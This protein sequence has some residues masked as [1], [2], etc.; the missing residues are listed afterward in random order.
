MKWN[1]EKVE[2]KTH[3]IQWKN[4]VLFGYTQFRSLAALSFSQI[5]RKFF[6][7][8]TLFTQNALKNI[9]KYF[10]LYCCLY[11]K[12]AW[13]I[14]WQSPTDFD[15]QQKEK[16]FYATNSTQIFEISTNWLLFFSLDFKWFLLLNLLYPYLAF[17]IQ[18]N[19]SIKLFLWLCLLLPF[20]YPLIYLQ[21]NLCWRQL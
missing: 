19:K 18:I 1:D 11:E 21:V 15:E 17:M 6:S 20:V 7:K 10:I 5:I 13:K 2:K 8:Y 4:G 9:H 14:G 12:K 16:Q 3:K